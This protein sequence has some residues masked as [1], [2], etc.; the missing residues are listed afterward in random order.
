MIRRQAV[1]SVAA[2]IALHAVAAAPNP[3]LEPPGELAK[4]RAWRPML[5]APLP[6]P[7]DLWL[8]CAA[9]TRAQ[10]DE[11]RKE[12]GPH[13]ERFI[14]VY[15]NP[16]ALAGLSGGARPSLA[17]GSII[18]KEKLPSSDAQ[19][20]AGV[21]FMVKRADPEFRSVGRVQF[22]DFPSTG[23]QRKTQKACA[24]CHRSAAAKD[25]VFGT[26]PR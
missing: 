17:P 21:A 12:H 16:E 18:A 7:M 11:T 26:Y 19:A 10:W 8:R 2:L 22:L 23:D 25:Y 15:A 9:P 14:Q 13:N 20:A 5:K 3:A 24:N 1:L 4:Y 6:V